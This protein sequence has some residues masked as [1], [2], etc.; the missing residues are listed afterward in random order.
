MLG[1]AWEARGR[2]GRSGL[3]LNFLLKP[4]FKEQL[5]P[6]H[7][8]LVV[9]LVVCIIVLSLDL[10]GRKDLFIGQLSAPSMTRLPTMRPALPRANTE[11]VHLIGLE[12]H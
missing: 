4:V 6:L 11:P 10:V 9:G 7:L 1:R 5:A 8:S 3:T 2:L 12:M